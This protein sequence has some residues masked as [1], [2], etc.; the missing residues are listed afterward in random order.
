MKT[1]IYYSLNKAT[2]PENLIA[3]SKIAPLEYTSIE[4]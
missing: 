2:L 4:S 1:T 3:T